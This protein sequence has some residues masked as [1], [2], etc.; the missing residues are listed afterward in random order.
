[1]PEPIVGPTGLLVA[2]NV[3]RIREAQR[4]TKQ[5]LS[6]KVGELGT[7]IPPLGIARIEAGTRRVDVDDLLALGR[8][9][10]VHGAELLR[11]PETTCTN[12]QGNPPPGFTCMVCLTFGPHIPGGPYA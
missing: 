6:D 2:S 12:C 1:M 7:P 4:F 8:A 3:R 11:E 9:L 5:A 10:G